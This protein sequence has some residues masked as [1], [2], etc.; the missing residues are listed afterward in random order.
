[1]GRNSFIKKTKTQPIIKKHM[2]S[3]VVYS[4]FLGSI[5]FLYTHL[6]KCNSSIENEII[7][8]TNEI[9][10]P[11]SF[12]I[13]KAFNALKNQTE[14]FNEQRTV[15]DTLTRSLT[16]TPHDTKL[17]NITISKSKSSIT[18]ETKKPL[19]AFNYQKRIKKSL[20]T[21]LISSPTINKTNHGTPYQFR[22]TIKKNE[23]KNQ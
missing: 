14:H 1:M 8:M 6:R 5:I 22:I 15:L 20:K 3:A 9:K 16:L 11:S 17:T 2:A 10:Q 4:A 18:G 12:D 13:K 23:I 7:K 19:N 21:D